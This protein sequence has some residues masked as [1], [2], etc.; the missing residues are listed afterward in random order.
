MNELK[1]NEL[2]E[3]LQDDDIKTLLDVIV[4]QNNELALKVCATLSDD[5]VIEFVK[6][7][8]KERNYIKRQM[9]SQAGA[10]VVMLKYKREVK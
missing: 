7:Y 10:N 8:N 1:N 5:I 4:E 6:L 9:N 2:A 3:E